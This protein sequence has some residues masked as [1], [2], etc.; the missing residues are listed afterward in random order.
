MN[1]FVKLNQFWYLPC[2]NDSGAGGSK[3]IKRVIEMLESC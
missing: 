2:Q 1:D 3:S